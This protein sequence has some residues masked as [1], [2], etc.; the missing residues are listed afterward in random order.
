MSITNHSLEE[1]ILPSSYAHTNSDNF[2]RERTGY[3]NLERD[4]NDLWTIIDELPCR[5][6]TQTSNDKCKIIDYIS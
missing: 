5:K 2:K 1:G 4:V 3:R 6:K